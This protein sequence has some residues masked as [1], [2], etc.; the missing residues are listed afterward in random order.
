L[1]MKVEAC[2]SCELPSL[3]FFVIVRGL[4]WATFTILHAPGAAGKG[5][6]RG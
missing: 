2:A 6:R 5:Q 1:R 4:G 3:L